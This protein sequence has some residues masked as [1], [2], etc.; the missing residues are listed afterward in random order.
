MRDSVL[1][2]YIYCLLFSYKIN[3][4]YWHK[5]GCWVQLNL[6]SNQT[7]SSFPISV[8]MFLK[9]FDKIENLS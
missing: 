6:D 4:I 8:L 7:M 5:L 3:I 1:Y 2:M 9:M